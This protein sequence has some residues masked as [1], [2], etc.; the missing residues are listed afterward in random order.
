[1]VA[2]VS[3]YLRDPGAELDLR[4]DES[5]YGRGEPIEV[6][7]TGGPANR[8]DWLGVFAADE[9]NPE[10]DDYLIWD[11]STDPGCTLHAARGSPTA[12]TPRL[13]TYTSDAPGQAV[14][15][16]G[17]VRRLTTLR[18]AVWRMAAPGR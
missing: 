10:K 11:W 2:R 14:A 5:T 6:S 3:F 4:T 7:W 1:M 9:S 8:W 12:G 17:G 18:A 15:G 13:T 16:T